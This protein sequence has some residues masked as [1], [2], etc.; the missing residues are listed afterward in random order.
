[1]PAKLRTLGLPAVLLA[2]TLPHAE[3]A[4]SHLVH[5]SVDGLGAVYLQP[6][7]SNAPAQFPAFRRLQTEGAFTYNARCDF[8]ASETIPNHTSM[9]TGRPALQPAGFPNTTHHG[10]LNNSPLPGETYHNSGNQ[11]VS[12]K[13]S[14]FDVLHDHGLST[15]LFTGKSKLEICNLSYDEE[16]G[17]EDFILPDHGRDK[18]DV[19]LTGDFSAYYGTDF[20]TQINALMANL[21]SPAPNRYNFLHISEPDL[22][23]HTTGWGNNNYSNM[24]RQV[25]A[26]LARIFNAVTTN[27]VLSNRTMLIVTTDHG[28]RGLFGH[29]DPQYRENYTIPFFLWGPGVAPGANLYSYFPNRADPGTNRL[30]YTVT[31][32]PIRN[33]DSGNLALLLLGLPPVPGSLMQ[34]WFAPDGV[35]LAHNPATSAAEISWPA[36]ATSFVLEYST[37]IGPA[38]LWQTQSTGISESSG[39]K[40]FP[41]NTGGP[42]VFY[43]L[44]KL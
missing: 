37:E 14:V 31:P 39:Q 32:Q 15:G 43:R 41:V 33:G 16:N 11:N 21:E 25:D 2:L 10:C 7:V 9:F 42:A 8:G 3:A 22:T 35:R 5:I 17:A 38:A 30:D 27:A 1:M 6:Y 44:R 13:A 36:A 40:V 24:V 28:G 4:V 18:I 20:T 34:P 12:Y 29:S 19:A 26:Q 23:G